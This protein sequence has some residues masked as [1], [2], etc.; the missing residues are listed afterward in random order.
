MDKELSDFASSSSNNSNNNYSSSFSTH[1]CSGHNDHLL[2]LSVVHANLA[3]LPGIRACELQFLDSLLSPAGAIAHCCQLVV[4]LEALPTIGAAAAATRSAYSASVLFLVRDVQVSLIKAGLNSDAAELNNLL[5]SRLLASFFVAFDSLAAATDAAADVSPPT[6]EAGGSGSTSGVQLRQPRAQPAKVKRVSYAG[7]PPPGSSASAAPT[8]A[9]VSMTVS[10]VTGSAA[11]DASSALSTTEERLSSGDA[12]LVADRQ[13]SI[14][15]GFGECLGLTTSRVKVPGL[16]G[17]RCWLLAVEEIQPGGQLDRQGVLQAGDLI[18]EVNE[19]PVDTP[20]ALRRM[21]R[22]LSGTVTFGL[23]TPPV[24]KSRQQRSGGATRQY[25]RAC[26]DYK[27]DLD[28]RLAQRRRRFV[29]RHKEDQQP[30]K[31]LQVTCGDILQVLLAGELDSA[32]G[33]EYWLARP[34]SE[35][36]GSGHAAWGLVPSL[37]TVRSMDDGNRRLSAPPRM[38]ASNASTSN[39]RRASSAALARS[40]SANQFP[41]AAVARRQQ[42]QAPASRYYELVSRARPQPVVC[43]V[44]AGPSGSSRSRLQRRLIDRLP[45]RFI[46]VA[47]ATNGSSGGRR[48]REELRRAHLAGELLEQSSGL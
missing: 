15:K 33:T 6:V 3:H 26:F 18:V 48:L 27:P 29:S 21:L 12:F 39:I 20:E 43:L 10:S 30:P 37:Q 31:G 19:Q 22:Q 40:A 11:L 46:A 8:T 4:L 5:S 42:P 2:P 14:Y 23:L 44:L 7:L 25:I 9:S 16:P 13:V 35:G 1:P 36:A 17:G 24:A 45:D 28:S 34:V 41:A 47:V 32:G 38:S